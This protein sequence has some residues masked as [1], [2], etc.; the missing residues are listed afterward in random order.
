MLKILLL[1]LLLPISTP[2]FGATA[3]AQPAASATDSDTQDRKSSAENE[4][5]MENIKA[6]MGL[7]LCGREIKKPIAFEE[8]SKTLDTEFKSITLPTLGSLVEAA[9]STHDPR[10]LQAL[11][12]KQLPKEAF[13]ARA[14]VLA[15]AKNCEYM[16]K[17]DIEIL[18]LLL[19][20]GGTP[21]DIEA[22]PFFNIVPSNHPLIALARCCPDP[23]ENRLFKDA[24]KLLIQHKIDLES[25]YCQEAGTDEYGNTVYGQGRALHEAARY[26]TA[27]WIDFLMH[28]GA[29]CKSLNI[30]GQF[31]ENVLEQRL[32]AEKKSAKAK[33][34]A[35]AATK[36]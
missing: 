14:L 7:Y 24:A 4:R 1:S 25:L 28:N 20:N 35:T 34:S 29:N 36:K 30:R 3:S 23:S 17:K 16:D 32:R 19:E 6:H 15:C 13:T 12:A 31:P 18:R 26:A 10:F 21:I 5:A 11:I 33:L 22:N 8:F 27:I 2:L 9:A